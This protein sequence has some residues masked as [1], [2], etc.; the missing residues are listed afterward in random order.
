MHWTIY[1]VYFL[2]LSSALLTQHQQQEREVIVRNGICGTETPSPA[3][4]DAH[5]RLATTD[6]QRVANTNGD[7]NKP[8]N[9]EVETYF[10][11][12]STNDQVN[13]VTNEMIASQVLA[14]CLAHLCVFI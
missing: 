13:L 7:N 2:S 12:V 9:I 10:H 5:R 4:K 1:Y 11:I 6:S 14:P 8:K 3:L